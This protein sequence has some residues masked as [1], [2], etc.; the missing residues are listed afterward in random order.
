MARQSPFRAFVVRDH[1][2]QTFRMSADT[3][4][5]LDQEH[6]LRLWSS[7]LFFPDQSLPS[8]NLSRAMRPVGR[9]IEK[10]CGLCRLHRW[11]DLFM[12]PA[13]AS[14]LIYRPRLVNS[15]NADPSDRRDR[16]PSALQ[17]TLFLWAGSSAV[18]SNRLII[19]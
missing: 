18:Q 17:S 5:G 13:T 3:L 1:R 16:G 19:G 9:P 11:R 10:P 2:W 14:I 12:G 15:F 8:V 6:V 7:P 4:H